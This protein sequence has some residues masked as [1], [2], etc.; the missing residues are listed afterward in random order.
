M[1]LFI[2]SDVFFFFLLFPAGYPSF[3]TVNRD[4]M[5]ILKVARTGKMVFSGFHEDRIFVYCRD[6]MNDEFL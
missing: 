6:E 2:I 5:E 3:E 4:E 1:I